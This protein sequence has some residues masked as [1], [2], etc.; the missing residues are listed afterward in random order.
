MG[1]IKT[2][3]DKSRKTP[4]YYWNK[5]PGFLNGEGAMNSIDKLLGANKSN[6]A[7][8]QPILYNL[9]GVDTWIV[10]VVNKI[11]G[12]FVRLGL[13]TAQSKYSVL[14]DNKADL[15]EAFKKAIV[16]GSINQNSDVK[17]N[18]NSQLKKV[19]KEGKIVRINQVVENGKTY[20]I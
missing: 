1:K 19:Q 12:S 15:L 3:L 4:V 10:P 2:N 17:V 14:A 5:T 20:F 8:V 18:N 13:V 7:T 16:D 9:Y 11:D 6:W